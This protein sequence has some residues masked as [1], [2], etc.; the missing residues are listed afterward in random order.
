[1]NDQFDWPMLRA[2]KGES[3]RGSDPARA[4]NEVVLGAWSI[5]AVFK[6]L[7]GEERREKDDHAWCESSLSTTGVVLKT[8]WLSNGRG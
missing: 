5:S 8:E 4:G 3:G 2:S 1:M 7:I 6:S